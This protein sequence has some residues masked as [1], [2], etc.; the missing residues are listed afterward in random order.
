MDEGVN[1]LFH[2]KLLTEANWWIQP[3]FHKR[4]KKKSGEKRLQRSCFTVNFTKFLRTLFLR[5]LT[6]AASEDENDDTKVLHMTSRLNEC[7]I[8]WF[9]VNFF[10]NPSKWTRSNIFL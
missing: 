5:T 4:N 6:V 1:Y 10:D 7:Y 3:Y 8:E 9:I 2:S